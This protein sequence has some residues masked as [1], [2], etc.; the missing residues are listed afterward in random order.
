[1]KYF[2]IVCVLCVALPF[3]YL[4]FKAVIRNNAPYKEKSLLTENELEFFWRLT[5]AL[6]ELFIFPQVAMSALIEPTASR[7]SK[8][9]MSSFGKISQKRVDYALYDSEM[10]IVCVIELDDKTHNADKDAA[11]DQLLKSANI[12]TLRWD[13]RNKPQA[14]EIQEKVLSPSPAIEERDVKRQ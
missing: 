10:K 4:L 2:V 3:L 13:A 5:R 6:P 1:M 9:H 8:S 11:R 12:R 14:S 7:G